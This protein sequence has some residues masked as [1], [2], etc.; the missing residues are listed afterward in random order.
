MLCVAT[1]ARRRSCVLFV[2]SS[3]TQAETIGSSLVALYIELVHTTGIVAQK[4]LTRFRFAFVLSCFIAHVR[5]SFPCSVT[6]CF[7]KKRHCFPCEDLSK[8]AGGVD[9]SLYFIG[10]IWCFVVASRTC[11]ILC[12]S[13]STDIAWC[14]CAGVRQQCLSFARFSDVR[15]S[16][17]HHLVWK[18]L[19]AAPTCTPRLCQMF[20]VGLRQQAVG[21]MCLIIYAAR[22]VPPSRR[23]RCV[24]AVLLECA[25]KSFVNVCARS[26]LV[27]VSIVARGDT[28]N[29]DPR[30]FGEKAQWRHNG[31]DRRV[32]RVRN[33]P[34]RPALFVFSSSVPSFKDGCVTPS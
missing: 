8:R 3:D 20:C 15:C 16:R 7:V 30:R 19:L 14:L 5:V 10:F 17:D 11:R 32:I 31:Y 1:F 25:M 21:C 34:G 29:D 28:T 23:L 22:W 33:S 18:Y 26:S 6:S 13:L 2:A 4:P 24:F 9:R 27:A 12:T